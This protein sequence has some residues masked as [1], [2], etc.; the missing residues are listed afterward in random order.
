MAQRSLGRGLG[1]LIPQ[2]QMQSDSSISER[3]SGAETGERVQEIQINLIQP[4]PHQ[5]REDFNRE[6]LEDLINSIKQ[7]GIIQPLIVLK[8]EQGYQLIA[9]E[10]RYRSAKILGLKTV[11]AIVRSASEQEKLE[12][13]I[14]ENIQRQ[15]L[16]P[17]ERAYGYQRLLEEFNLTQ[18]QVA[19]RMGQ[20]RAVVA[21]SLRLL[22]LPPEIQKALK[23][24][25]ITE[26]HAKVLLSITSEP[27]RLRVC[28]EIIKD[29]LSVRAV[30]NQARKVSV[31]RHVRKVNKDP[32]MAAR[33]EALQ[34]SLGTKVTITRKGQQGTINIHFYSAEEFKAI[35]NKITS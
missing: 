32:N 22:T 16:N 5:P 21:N 26:G 20:H 8:H 27:E 14:V 28:K 25:D 31:R 13:A 23:E 9:G 17:I 12:L 29:K 3:N 19:K 35:I 11:P 2:R 7:H 34:E 1:S 33:E 6:K 30:E 18:E 10:R 24:G 15:N 4:N